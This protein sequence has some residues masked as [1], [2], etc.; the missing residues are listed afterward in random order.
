M[1]TYRLIFTVLLFGEGNHLGSHLDQ[2]PKDGVPSG[3]SDNVQ[4]ITLVVVENTKV[5]VLS[6][7]SH[8]VP[9]AWGEQGIL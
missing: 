5:V 2:F 8:C 4:G 3:P 9:S 7:S 6:L 1:C